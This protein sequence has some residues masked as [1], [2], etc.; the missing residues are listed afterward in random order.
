M[1]NK[2]WYPILTW[3]LIVFFTVLYISL[4]FNN[5]IVTDEAFTM[6]LLGGNFR[7]IIAGTAND[8]HPPLYY[9]IG[10]IFQIVFGNSLQVQKIAAIIPTVFTLL[11]GPWKVRKHF[12]WKTAFFFVLSIACI[13][14]SMQFAL[15]VRMY[16]LALFCVTACGLFA[17]ECFNLEEKNIWSWIGLVLSALGAAYAHYF[18]LVAVIAINGLFLIAILCKKRSLWKNWLA[19]SAAMI[20][21]YL[22]WFG[23]LLWQV[24]NVTTSYWIPPITKD[25][26]WGYFTWTFGLE[27]FPWT[28]YVFLLLL[29]FA[30]ITSLVAIWKRK[31]QE[32]VYAQL[33]MLVPT[34]VCVIGVGFSLLTRPVYREQY[35]FPAI[36]LLCLFFAIAVRNYPEK[37]LIPIAAFLLFVGAFQYKENFREEYRSTYVPQMEAFFEENLQADDCIIYNFEV[38]GF[39]YKYYF[40]ENDCIYMGDWNPDNEYHR[41]YFLDTASELKFTDGQLA[42]WGYTRTLAGHFGIEQNEFDIYVLEKQ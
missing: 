31:E 15:Q 16:S 19:A 5:N 39:I 23:I 20:L 18:A 40:P 34:A 12:G 13:P 42:E 21:G 9:I 2:N 11:L 17:Y 30:G 29:I 28:T 6:Q 36:G 4:I 22:P 32:S 8:V 27:Q 26:C 33:C 37:I 10:K 35:V 14:C 24:G 25:V 1:K 7:E 38:L 41:T 3:G